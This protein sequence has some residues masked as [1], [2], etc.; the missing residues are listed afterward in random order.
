M[1][2]LILALFIPVSTPT[3][4]V[5][6]GPV[7]AIYLPAGWSGPVVAAPFSEAVFD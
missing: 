3:A 7:E 2:T 5:E 1:I 6:S 4:H